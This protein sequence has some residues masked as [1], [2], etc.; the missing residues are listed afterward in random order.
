MKI[1]INLKKRKFWFNKRTKKNK[2]INKKFL[3][4]YIKG[5]NIL[6]LSFLCYYLFYKHSKY[7]IIEVD[8]HLSQ[9]NG[10]GP[11]QFQKGIAKILPYRTKNCLFIPSNT[12]SLKNA[13]NN[14]NYF[15]ISAPYFDKN[16]ME[17]WKKINRCNDLLL[18]PNYV[19]VFWSAFP[20]QSFWGEKNFR[21]VLQNIKGY[22]LH[23]NRVRTHLSTRSNTTDI[24]NKYIIVRACSYILPKIV[25]PFDERQID[26]LF[27]EKFPDSNRRQQSEKL[28]KLF[29][30]SG[31]K[32][33]R[34]KYGNYTK[35]QML[36]LSNNTKFI[37]YFSFYDTGAIGLKEIQNFGVFSFTLQEDLAIHNYTSL[38]VPEL[39]NIDD[40][41]SAFK[42]IT[43]KM[44]LISESH[45]NTQ[46][47][48][49]IN[50]NINRCE[51]AL[52]DMCKGLFNN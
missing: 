31:K 32:L 6:I 5:I 40:M 13:K 11:V 15:Y 1:K 41:E 52:E 48:A 36:E 33:I 29:N 14:S 22:V 30:D 12:I 49:E 23:S 19:P 26:I 45:P 17:K 8:T 51:R 24:L 16:I 38:Y 20:I 7:K 37:I 34:M 50:Q 35:D 42:I 25:K 27:F 10:G 43:K 47:M 28:V 39:E 9:K 44:D 2:I 46:K 18:G 21:E 3:Y 4:I